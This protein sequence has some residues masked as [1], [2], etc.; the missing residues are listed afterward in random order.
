MSQLTKSLTTRI[1]ELTTSIESQTSELAA[2]KEVLQIEVAKETTPSGSI[3][4]GIPAQSSLVSSNG[5]SG[6]DLTGVEFGGNKTAF[7]VAIVKAHGAA[8]ATP[9]EIR[10]VFASRKIPQSDNLIYTTLSALAKDKKLQRRDGR[11]FGAGSSATVSKNGST[12]TA[13]KS[14][15]AAPAAKKKMSPAALKR[16]RQGVKK[17]WAAKRA[18]K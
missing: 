12:A 8:G 13:K 15:S 3:P 4:S 9:K 14:G 17:Y 5:T 1:Q 10:E 6:I 2:Y 7:V 16:L 11:Y 18:A